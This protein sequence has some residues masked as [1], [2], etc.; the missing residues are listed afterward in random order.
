MLW[1]RG[2]L[3]QKGGQELFDIR[4][5]EVFGNQSRG[6]RG[7]LG[8]KILPSFLYIYLFPIY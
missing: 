4:R 5:K 8:G 3:A 7:I 2:Q 1:L 6:L